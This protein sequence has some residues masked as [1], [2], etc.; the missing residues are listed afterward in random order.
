MNSQPPQ[1]KKDSV[2]TYKDLTKFLITIST[3][4]FVLSPAFLGNFKEI[5]FL[6]CLFASWLC[7]V[8]SIILGLLV[9]SSLAGTQNKN[10]YDIDNRL[11]K[12]LSRPQWFLLVLAIVLFGIFIGR[13]LILKQKSNSQHPRKEPHIE[14][15]YQ[16]LHKK[17]SR[18]G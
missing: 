16:P 1:H 3:G 12:W 2:E 9:L 14:S 17:K 8:I 10:E 15:L 7:L 5:D 18:R 13:N 11:T 6:T 4:V